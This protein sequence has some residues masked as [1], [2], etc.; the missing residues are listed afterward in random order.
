M[1]KLT[2]KFPAAQSNTRSLSV[3]PEL[4]LRGAPAG[5]FACG[6]CATV[7]TPELLRDLDALFRKADSNHDGVLSLPE[8]QR[9]VADG[10]V[11]AKYPHAQ[12]FFSRIDSHFAAADSEHTGA[13]NRA[14]F[15]TLLKDVDRNRRSL[16]ATAQVADQQGRYLAGVLNARSNQWDVAA[17]ATEAFHFRNRGQ[18]AYVGNNVAVI[19]V[20][21]DSKLVMG[22]AHLTHLVWRAAYWAMLSTGRTKL[23]VGLDWIKTKLA[24]RDTSR[25]R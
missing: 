21:E 25:W 7:D 10:A 18:M 4:T 11:R 24:G 15:Q 3:S 17:A 5:V 19:G 13:L 8:L 20:G 16:P 12:N 1:E 2:A 23:S 6:D 22:D 14:Q 9:L